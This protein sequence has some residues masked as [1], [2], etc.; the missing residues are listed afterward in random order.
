ME[1]R[2]LPADA[3]CLIYIAKIDA[4]ELAGRCVPRLLVPPAVWRESVVDAERLGY[5]DAQRIRAAEQTGIVHSVALDAETG[6]RAADLASSWRI[7]QG[8]SETLALARDVGRAIVDDGRAARV[9]EAVGIEPVSTLFLPVL[10][11]LAG[12]SRADATGFLRRLAIVA[13]ARAETAL[14]VEEFIGRLT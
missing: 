14:E 2:G 4:F 5:T 9:A 1:E 6:R 7:G 8:E 12:M 13:S 3:T 11:A 10:G